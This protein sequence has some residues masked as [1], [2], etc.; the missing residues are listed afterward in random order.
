ML[1]LL[2]AV[3]VK[4]AVERGY[5]RNLEDRKGKPAR[6]VVGDQMPEDQEILPVP[7][8]LAS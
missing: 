2:L 6:L 7:E 5:L 3:R 1:R 8:D 4:V